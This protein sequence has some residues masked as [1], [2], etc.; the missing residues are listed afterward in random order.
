MEDQKT[1]DYAKLQAISLACPGNRFW[2][3]AISNIVAQ[4]KHE[5]TTDEP[6]ISLRE[7]RAAIIAEL[8]S[9]GALTVQP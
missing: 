1:I 3:K 6:S 5:A 7:E 4:V 9:N 2:R 8:I